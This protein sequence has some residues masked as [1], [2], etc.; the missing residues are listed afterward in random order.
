MLGG[1]S[2]CAAVASA[3]FASRY[4]PVTFCALSGLTLIVGH[5]VVGPA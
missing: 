3:L 4:P 2:P 1:A 5:D